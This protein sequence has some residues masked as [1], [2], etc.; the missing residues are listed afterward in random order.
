MFFSFF[1]FENMSSNSNIKSCNFVNISYISII[2][3]FDSS[4][5]VTYIFFIFLNNFSFTLSLIFFASSFISDSTFF[6]DQ[7]INFM[8]CTIS[9]DLFQLS[10]FFSRLSNCSKS[11]AIIFAKSSNSESFIRLACISFNIILSSFI[12]SLTSF[13]KISPQIVFPKSSVSFPLRSN[14]FIFSSSHFLGSGDDEMNVCIFSISS[15]NGVS[16]R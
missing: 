11:L 14:V 16:S 6:L 5:F 15:F 3:W 1:L 7:G 12:S 9:Y 2:S 13:T 8:F 10:K 4:E